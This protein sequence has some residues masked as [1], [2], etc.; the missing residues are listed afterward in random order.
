ML[1]MFRPPKSPSP[2]AVAANKR[3]GRREN[4]FVADGDVQPREM[5]HPGRA[6]SHLAT[7]VSF[8]PSLC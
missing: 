3:A 2:S 1:Q 6:E 7:M 5:I 8:V 4:R